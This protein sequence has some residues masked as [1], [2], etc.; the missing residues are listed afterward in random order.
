MTG[1]FQVGDRVGVKDSPDFTH[2]TSRGIIVGIGEAAD[3]A[4]PSVQVQVDGVPG[5]LPVLCRLLVKLPSLAPGAVADDWCAQAYPTN[6]DDPGLPMYFA[7]GGDL[8][9]FVR[10]FQAL[11]LD[12][13]LKVH[14][15]ATASEAERAAL[16]GAGVAEM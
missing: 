4:A 13:A 16:K 6:G 14:V 11:E 8:L 15:P 9:E 1:D 2:W 10:Q 7:T 3:G 5:N 12:E